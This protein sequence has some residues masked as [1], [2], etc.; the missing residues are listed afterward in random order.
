MIFPWIKVAGMLFIAALLAMII[1]R[2]S[3]SKGGHVQRACLISLIITGAG[4]LCGIY[5]I[6][7]AWGK[8]VYGV[9]IGIMVASVIRLLI[10][11]AGVAIITFFNSVHRSWFVLFLGLYY[12]LFLAVE[13]WLA[14]WVLR[15]SQLDDR[16]S[17]VHGNFW[18]L[19]S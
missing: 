9:L 16:K 7:R 12:L 8:D 15:N 5:P 4:G 1:Y 17:S 18:D 6:S 19:I 14:L 3:E 10:S 2:M 13:T 11:G